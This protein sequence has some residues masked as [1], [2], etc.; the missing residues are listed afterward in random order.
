MQHSPTLSTLLFPG[1]RRSLLSLLLL[2]SDD[3]LHGREI[4]RRVNLPSGSVIR[5][6]NRLAEV[7]LLRREKRGNQAVYSE[8]GDSPVFQ[9]VASI[10]RKTAGLADVLKGALAPLTEQ[11]DVAFVF[12][13]LAR[14]AETRGSDID[15]MAIGTVDFGA[16]VDALYPAQQLLGREINP[17]VF[18]VKE[19]NQK[20][21]AKDPFL[22]EVKTREKIFLIGGRNE[23]A[24]LGRQ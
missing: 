7:G 18:G 23:L 6:L 12:G 16:V 10:L 1:Y 17:K 15:L 22:V 14:G 20:L 11:I 24:K 19:W 2:R 4:A 21:K 8:N 3:A 9:E 13:S 5:E